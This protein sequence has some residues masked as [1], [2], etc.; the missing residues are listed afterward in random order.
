M[1]KTMRIANLSDGC[2]MKTPKLFL[3]NI[4][5]RLNTDIVTFLITEIDGYGQKK[6]AWL[7]VAD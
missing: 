2:F 3:I 5:S 4:K 1:T 6:K 7:W